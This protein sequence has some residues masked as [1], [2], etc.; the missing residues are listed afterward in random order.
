MSESHTDR[1]A[2][3]AAR[4]PQ[5]DER[6]RRRVEHAREIAVSEAAAIAA[7]YEGINLADAGLVYAHAFGYTRAT[8]RELLEVIDELTGGAR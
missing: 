5:M 7:G 3:S 1:R 6:Q 2:V 8:V 4:K